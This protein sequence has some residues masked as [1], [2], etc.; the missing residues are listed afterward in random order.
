MTAASGPD[1]YGCMPRDPVPEG[2]DCA[3]SEYGCCS[4]GRTAAE[5]PNA[6]GCPAVDCTV[7]AVAFFPL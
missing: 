2:I 7:T 1:Y 5:G 4:D 6:E 3:F